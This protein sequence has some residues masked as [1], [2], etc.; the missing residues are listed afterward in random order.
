MSLALF[1]ILTS[2]K[3]SIERGL[4]WPAYLSW[5][6]H[7]SFS[8]ITSLCS[9]IFSFY[10]YMWN[11]LL[12][13]LH[14]YFLSSP[15]RMVVH[16]R[17]HLV[18]LFLA[19]RL[20]LTCRYWHILAEWTHMFKKRKKNSKQNYIS[21]LWLNSKTPKTELLTFLS[22]VTYIGLLLKLQHRKKQWWVNF[23][24][25]NLLEFQNLV[26]KHLFSVFLEI[27]WLE[28]GRRH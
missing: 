5:S 27:K 7:A 22:Q 14:V 25:H 1:I 23:S 19:S 21:L 26:P 12:I 18:H 28:L 8:V 16:K 10:H 9:M 24:K 20:C 15:G 17:Y 6:P 11:N 4:T 3:M 13:R 2:L